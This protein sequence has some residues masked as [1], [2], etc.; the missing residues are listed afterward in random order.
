MKRDHAS[1]PVGADQV[2]PLVS[3]GAPGAASALVL[4]LVVVACA[5]VCAIDVAI[6]ALSD[7]LIAAA[8]V[9]AAA[10]LAAPLI[11][12]ST[13]SPLPAALRFTS[14]AALGLGLFALWALGLGL[15]G[16]LNRLTA[17][18]PPAS[19]LAVGLARMLRRG[20]INARLDGSFAGLARRLARPAGVFWL[21]LAAA[22]FAAVALAGVSIMPGYLWKPFDPHPYDVM[23]YHLQIPRE[24]YES[25]RITPLLHNV[26]CFF[27]FHMEMHYLL[28]MHLRGGP[29]AGMYLAQWLS[30]AHMILAVTAVYALTTELVARTSPPHPRGPLVAAV[31]AA[32]VPWLAMLGSVA[33]VESALLLYATLALAWAIRG[34][35][36]ASLRCFAAG[37]AMAGLA[38][39]TKYT[40]APTVLVLIPLGILLWR[41]AARIAHAV[42]RR[43]DAPS[44]HHDWAGMR[45]PAALGVWLLVG[46]ALFAPWLVRNAVWTGNPVFP[47]AMRLLGRAHFDQVQMERFERAHSAPADCTS[48]SARLAAFMRRVVLDWQYGYAL[49]PIAAAAAILGRRTLWMPLLTL[50]ICLEIAFWLFFT[51]LEPRF[52]VLIVPLA[53]AIVGAAVHERPLFAA[54]AALFIAI[55]GLSCLLPRFMPLARRA[56]QGLY[57][58]DDPAA[59]T[60]EI[61]RIQTPDVRLAHIGGCQPFFDT[62]PASRLRYRTIFD[63]RFP[64]GK[65]VLDAWL[66]RDLAELARDHIVVIHPGEI[67]R[68]S[69]TYWQVPPLPHDWRRQL[70][71]VY[72][73]IPPVYAGDDDSPVIYAPLK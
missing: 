22:P 60:P 35:N 19:G 62:V 44:L 57:R 58:L 43:P 5:D 32:S 2:L 72:G 25:G 7:G 47:L 69:Q 30:F 24:W 39:G 15:A 16:W 59:L 28:A 71:T 21:V 63:I 20:D 27:P 12:R 18:V 4:V 42:S 54:V 38:C 36:T 37:G 50:L 6:G 10:M 8:W 1:P 55:A 40:A 23:A 56:Q 61:A 31:S 14:A 52:A 70:R 13:A 66:G 9:L 3:W 49:L 46:L 34:L 17:L 41:L 11:P 26:Y 67:K 68:L 65:S 64:P 53:A 73:D 29:W 45:L 48:V 33:Y 51:H